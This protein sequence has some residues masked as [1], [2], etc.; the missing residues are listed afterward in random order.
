MKKTQKPKLTMG[1]ANNPGRTLCT[2]LL[3]V[4][5]TMKTRTLRKSDYRTEMTPANRTIMMCTRTR[6]IA[7]RRTLIILTLSVFASLEGVRVRHHCR[8]PEDESRHVR[9]RQTLHPPRWATNWC[10]ALY[11]NRCINAATSTY[12]TDALTHRKVG[13]CGW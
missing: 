11:L 8:D 13:G 3:I 6:R 7:L 9:W 12:Y 4:C 1:T 10:N 5:D 2:G